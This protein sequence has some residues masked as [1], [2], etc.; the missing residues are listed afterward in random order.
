MNFFDAQTQRAELAHQLQ[1]HDGL[2]V[3]CYCAAW[4]DTCNAYR[5][6]FEALASRLP[7]HLFVWIDIEESEELLDD[8]DIENFPTIVVQSDRG[9]H[10]YGVMLPHPEH[11]ER[12]L[13]SL[14][15]S[16]SVGPSGP[17]SLRGLIG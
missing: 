13:Q 4:C 9:N 6:G 11:L 1:T 2:V 7:D 5:P 8:E 15:V 14:E 16:S 17:A 3:A 12:L 10:F